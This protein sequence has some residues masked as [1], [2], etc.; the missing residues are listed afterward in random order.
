MAEGDYFWRVSAITGKPGPVKPVK[1]E[2]FLFPGT[3]LSR[4]WTP[5]DGEI[6]EYKDGPPL[7]VFTWE[8][9]RLAESYILEL[10]DRSDFSKVLKRIDSRVVNFSYQWEGSMKPG[11]SKTLYWRVTA[12]GGPRGWQGRRSDSSHFIVKRGDR[13][14]PPRL[15]YP[16]RW[17]K[18]EPVARR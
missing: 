13:L 5:S 2:G 17:E 9:H 4:C 14:D 1:Q 8:P 3:I 11:D 15:V 18:H 10:S 12:T 6:V 7:I 16:D